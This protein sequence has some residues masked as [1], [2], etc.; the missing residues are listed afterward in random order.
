MMNSTTKN[1]TKD[2]LLKLFVLLF[3]LGI[4]QACA[5]IINDSYFLPSIPE[6]LMALFSLLV[7]AEFLLTVLLTLAR[8]L[9]GLL[10][11]IIFGI[12]LST[13][14]YNFKI[15]NALISPAMSVIKSTPVAAFVIL[16]WVLLSGDALTIVIAVLMV[17]PIIWQNLMD[18]YRAIPNDLSEVADVFSFTIFKRIRLVI[19]PT[20]FKY[21]MPALIT[22]AGLAWKSE[23]AA[24][25]IA[26]TENSIG[27]EIN[28]A[29]SN[30]DTPSVFAWTIVII[31][32]S[33]LIEFLLK[34]FK[35][36]HINKQER[37]A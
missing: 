25:I 29:T 37:S 22:S 11:G 24:E 9:L 5:M 8:V 18:G 16:L 21:F 1:K 2:I 15:A 20:L 23:I 26:Y 17:M 33:M 14:C 34:Y 35:K 13:L 36:K 27:H 10:L 7:S 4:W 3:W 19:F 28:D 30:F 12:L 31:V 6:T 32:F